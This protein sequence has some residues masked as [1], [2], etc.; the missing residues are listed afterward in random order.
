MMDKTRALQNW[1]QHV[2]TSAPCTPARM[3]E[4]IA[5]NGRIPSSSRAFADSYLPEHRRDLYSVIGIGVS[6]DPNFKPAVPHADNFHVDYIVAPTGCGAALHCHDSE[7]VFISGAGRWEVY[8]VDGTDQQQHSIILDPRDTISVPPWV[9][10]GFR[11]L[12]GEAGFLIAILGGRTPGHV[13]WDRSLAE[14]AKAI[15]VGFDDDGSAVK[16]DPS[17]G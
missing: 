17:V 2:A 6:D 8:W 7:E 14:R 1:A 15:G 4:R 5:R 12:D 9:M 16:F 10:R 3:A 13:K 11:S